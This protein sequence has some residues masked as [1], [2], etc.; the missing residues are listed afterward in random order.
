MRMW[1]MLVVNQILM[2]Q[3]MA[4]KANVI[5]QYNDSLNMKTRLYRQ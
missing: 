3:I 1:P 5:A 2:S 4:K